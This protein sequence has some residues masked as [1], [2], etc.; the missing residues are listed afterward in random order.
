M[1][2]IPLSDIFRLN[3]NQG[4][5]SVSVQVPTWELLQGFQPGQR[6]PPMGQMLRGPTIG[7]PGPPGLQFKP[8]EI[9][10]PGLML[11]LRVPF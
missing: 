3:P 7:V 1:N 5:P 11:R 6:P 8:T 9:P 10:Q 2:E 4:D